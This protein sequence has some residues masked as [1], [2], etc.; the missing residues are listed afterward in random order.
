MR[1]EYPIRLLHTHEQLCH[2][3]QSCNLRIIPTARLIFLLDEENCNRFMAVNCSL[4]MSRRLE[5]VTL[6][7]QRGY[8]V[9]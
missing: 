7:S 1:L 9:K 2:C 8:S 4:L 5:T 3:F 6:V